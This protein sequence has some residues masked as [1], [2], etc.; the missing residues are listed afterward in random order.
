M[1]TPIPNVTIGTQIKYFGCLLSN[2]DISTSISL[3]VFIFLKINCNYLGALYV[4]PVTLIKIILNIKVSW[5]LTTLIF[6]LGMLGP[7][8]RQLCFSSPASSEYGR[9]LLRDRIDAWM[10]YSL[11][12]I[13]GLPS[14]FLISWVLL[15]AVC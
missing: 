14:S 11:L 13:V 12:L 8:T 9:Q 2:L 1:P 3:L 7:R 15:Q 5:S 10:A 6:L 4:L